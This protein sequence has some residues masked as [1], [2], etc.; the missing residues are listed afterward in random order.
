MLLVHGRALKHVAVGNMV[1]MSSPKGDQGM[2]VLAICRRINAASLNVIYPTKPMG[3]HLVSCTEFDD[4]PVRATDVRPVSAIR[5][6]ANR[7]YERFATW[8]ASL[9]LAQTTLPKSIA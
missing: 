7:W 5:R 8:T 3:K 9:M 4:A 2:R 6:N 1:A